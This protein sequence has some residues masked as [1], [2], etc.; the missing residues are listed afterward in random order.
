M[1]STDLLGRLRG[2]GRFALVEFLTMNPPSIVAT[3][4][5]PRAVVQTLF[6]TVLGGVLSGADGRRFAFV[7]GLAMS[8][9]AVLIGD[10][11]EVPVADK[12]AGTFGRLRTGVLHPFVLFVVRCWPYP[13]TATALTAVTI[14]C[15][16]PLTGQSGLVLP[17]LSWLPV[18]LLMALT[19][20]ATV[21]AAALL[22]LGRRAELLATNAVSFGILLAGGVFLP[23]GR[24][25]VVD[26][27]GTVLPI[28][29]GL[30]ALR[31]GLDGRPFAGELAAEA[32]VGAGWL[33]VAFV[34][35]VVQARR[36]HRLGIDDFA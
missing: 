2:V 10:V 29:H 30:L 20:A 25:P 24:V 26:A 6:F 14:V 13:V 34:V 22:A 15:V 33:L 35:T 11:G 21:L 27:V 31:A 23:P 19:S 12:W 8:L 4:L 18:Y 16:G 1:S 36:A 3:A 7:G 5:L 28:R 9:V 32:L 17:L